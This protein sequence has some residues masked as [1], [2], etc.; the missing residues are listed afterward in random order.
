[1]VFYNYSSIPQPTYL[2]CAYRF[3]DKDGPDLT[4]CYVVWIVIP[5]CFV[6]IFVAYYFVRPSI[7]YMIEDIQTMAKGIWWL[8]KKTWS[9]IKH[10]F[11]RGLTRTTSDLTV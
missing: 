10:P 2:E 8:L 7:T 9:F 11:K 1:M 3:N 5:V 4:E 6:L